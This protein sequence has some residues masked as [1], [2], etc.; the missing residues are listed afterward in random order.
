[1]YSYGKIALY[2][3]VKDSISLNNCLYNGIHFSYSNLTSKVKLD[4]MVYYGVRAFF[5]PTE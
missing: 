3:A 5:S 4:T 1:M 2:N